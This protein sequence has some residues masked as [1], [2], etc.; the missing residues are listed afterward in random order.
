M[1]LLPS[2][3]K[4]LTISFKIL[5]NIGTLL[6]DVLKLNYLIVLLLLDFIYIVALL[7]LVPETF[8]FMF[9]VSSLH[10]KQ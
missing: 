5:S 3:K 8:G 10:F 7:L 4:L 2:N 6:N 1:N 9:S